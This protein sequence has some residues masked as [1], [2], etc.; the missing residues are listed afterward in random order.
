MTTGDLPAKSSLSRAMAVLDLIAERA[1]ETLGVTAVAKE[2]GM[3]KAVGHRILKEFVAGN[4][5][6]FD[7]DTKQ[8]SLGSHALT[9]GLSALRTLN[10]PAAARP[11]L[12]RLVAESGETTTLSMRQGRSR[13]YI[14]QVV[15]PSEVRMT[16]A[17]GTQHPL[18]A[19]SSSKSILAAM[20]SAEVDDYLANVAL[21]RLTASTITSANKLRDELRSIAARGY[22][23]S[24]GE[25]ESAAGSVAAAI[26]DANGGVWGSVSVCGPR[27]RFDEAACE[28]YGRLVAEAAYEISRSVGHRP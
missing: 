16:V 26:H 6:V 12:E 25:R 7:N 15:S 5:L 20:S 14:D 27:D 22:A 21:P 4:Y 1:P 8:Y 2:L 9:I 11:H 17:L 28:R 3:P 19:G 10:V 24:M 23:V 13:L 18:H